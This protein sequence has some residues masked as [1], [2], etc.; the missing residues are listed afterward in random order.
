MNA[1]ERV[2]HGLYSSCLRGP[3]NPHLS[4]GLEHTSLNALDAALE[5][6]LDW[7]CKYADRP[8]FQQQ[9]SFASFLSFVDTVTALCKE[10]GEKSDSSAGAQHML[11]VH[12]FL[13]LGGKTA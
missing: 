6:P 13:T 12:P 7:L 5:R 8:P 4:D 1:T 9:S 3:V 11:G 10:G 2:S